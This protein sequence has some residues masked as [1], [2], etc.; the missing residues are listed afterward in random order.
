MCSSLG[1]NAPRTLLTF[2]GRNNPV[3]SWLYVV[4]VGKTTDVSKRIR[5]TGTSMAMTD[6]NVQI[7]EKKHSLSL[8][9]QNSEIETVFFVSFPQ[10]DLIIARI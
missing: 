1:F 4:H 10:P 8:L 7:A 3:R 2:R 5:G 6:L 9:W